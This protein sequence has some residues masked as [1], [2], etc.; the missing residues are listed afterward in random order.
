MSGLAS[1]IRAPDPAAAPYVAALWDAGLPQS[2]LAVSVLPDATAV[3]ALHYGS[4]VTSG[5]GGRLRH[6]RSH[7]SGLHVTPVTVL[8]PAGAASIVVRLTPLGMARVLGMPARLTAGLQ[9]EAADLFGTATVARLEDRLAAAPD[10]AARSAIACR[11]V[12]DRV[13]AT[14]EVA[15]PLATDA[16]ARLGAASGMMRIADLA[17]LYSLSERQFHRRFTAETGIAAKTAA[18]ILR[19]QAAL[20][21]RHHGDSWSAAA[22][23]AGY[24]DQA[25][26][27][28]EFRRSAGSAPARFFRD[29]RPAGLSDFF[30]TF[31]A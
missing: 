6:G 8:A 9:V 7:V 18:R 4:P 10:A 19:L 13:A 28:R 26:L 17:A 27:V 2:G 30:N 1:E 23:S 16:M 14:R 15:D 5:L 22:A 31:V 24:S 20:R 12:L 29:H 3:L 21:A 11:F 25:H